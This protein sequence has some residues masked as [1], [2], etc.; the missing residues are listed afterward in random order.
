MLL[1]EWLHGLASQHGRET[2]RL[3]ELLSVVALSTV[4]S[5]QR[6]RDGL[7][8]GTVKNCRTP[9][10]I[11]ADIKCGEILSRRNVLPLL[12]L[13]LLLLLFLLLLL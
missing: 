10:L 13:L 9:G 11:K 6:S 12:S 1:P 3:R 8:R 5:L 7:W 4:E 2:D